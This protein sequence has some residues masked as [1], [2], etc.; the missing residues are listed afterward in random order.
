MPQGIPCAA[1]AR[2]SHCVRKELGFGD[3]VLV[4]LPAWRHVADGSAGK[5]MAVVIEDL[6]RSVRVAL[7][8]TSRI[9]KHLPE[10]LLRPRIEGDGPGVG[11][12]LATTSEVVLE[13]DGRVL[14]DKA[15]ILPHHHGGLKRGCLS[16]EDRALIWDLSAFISG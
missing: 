12:S 7:T 15:S 9:A 5:R 16:P 11:N 4:D 13:P 1:L 2:P 6:G 14:I 10:A 8:S 3:T